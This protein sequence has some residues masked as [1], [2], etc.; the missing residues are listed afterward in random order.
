MKRKKRSLHLLKR[1][2]SGARVGAVAC[3]TIYW[4]ILRS[5]SLPQP[6]SPVVIG[7]SPHGDLHRRA[8][9]DQAYSKSMPFAG[10]VRGDV[11]VDIFRSKDISNRGGVVLRITSRGDPECFIAHAEFIDGGIELH[12]AGETESRSLLEVLRTAIA[13]MCVQDLLTS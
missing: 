1:R 13:E 7:R 12:M 10:G 2:P 5:V 9:T 11:T 4:L 3:A 8:E 6:K